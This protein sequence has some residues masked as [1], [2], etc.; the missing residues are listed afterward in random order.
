MASVTSSPFRKEA[1]LVQ[2][3]S[4]MGFILALVSTVSILPAILCHHTQLCL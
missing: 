1:V 2:A 4:Y 3:S